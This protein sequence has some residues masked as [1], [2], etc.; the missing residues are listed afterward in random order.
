MGKLDDIRNLC[1]KHRPVLLYLFFGV[2][3]T[4]VNVACY[5]LLYKTLGVSNLYSSVLAWAASVLFAYGTNRR[6][7][8]QSAAKGLREVFLE[9]VSFFG[10]RLATGVLDVLIMVAAV[11]LMHWDGTLFK[12]L[13]NVLVIAVNYAAS[14]WLIFKER[15]KA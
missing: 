1:R 5:R 15:K 10:C 9:A 11:D 12:I 13:S 4:A 6:Y 2:C 14:K 3:T 7:V 8:F